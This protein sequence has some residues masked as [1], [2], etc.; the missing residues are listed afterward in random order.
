MKLTKGDYIKAKVKRAEDRGFANG[1]AFALIQIVL[2][3]PS[4]ERDAKSVA[5]AAG[6]TLE[7]FKDTGIDKE[8]QVWRRLRT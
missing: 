6:L 7:D 3:N 5:D 1:M 4:C 2:E 8:E